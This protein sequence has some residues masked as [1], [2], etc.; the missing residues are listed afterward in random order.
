M[1]ETGSGDRLSTR[2]KRLPGDLALALVNA[3]A[4]LILLTAGVGLW[5][6]DRVQGAVADTAAE[7]TRAV[8]ESAQLD[9]QTSAK[10]LPRPTFS[11]PMMQEQETFICDDIY[12][13]LTPQGG[14]TDKKRS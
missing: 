14:G 13:V 11:S 2:L 5:F 4:L 12:L 9:A 10:Y 1:A 7:A 6:V 8:L 3:T